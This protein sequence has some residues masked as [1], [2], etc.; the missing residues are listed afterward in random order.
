MSKISIIIPAH[1]ESENLPKLIK[2]LEETL[3]KEDFEVIIVNDDNQAASIETI[4]KLKKE[5]GQVKALFFD[6][7]IGKTRSI[8]EGFKISGGDIIVIMDADLQYTPADIPRLVEGLKQADVV[9][10]LRENRKDQLL[11]ILESKIYNLLMRLF[12]GLRVHDCN[13][14]LKVLKRRVMEDIA[15]QLRRGWHRYILAL[16]VKKG[17]SIIEI[18]V[19]HYARAFGKSKFSSSP[20]KL[21]H[22]FCDLLSVRRIMTR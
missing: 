22:G 9:N 11:R 1:M 8:R 15:E 17:Y 18:S 21:L 6:Q 12:F 7:R 14:G 10:G 16:T 2:K 5:Y 13:S 4:E 3:W 19:R 20:L